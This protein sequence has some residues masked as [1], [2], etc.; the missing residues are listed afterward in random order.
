M[1]TAEAETHS[2]SAS[3]M[4]RIAAQLPEG[5]MCEACPALEFVCRENLVRIDGD[6]KARALY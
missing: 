1:A 3:A 6:P 2:G 5:A 4:F